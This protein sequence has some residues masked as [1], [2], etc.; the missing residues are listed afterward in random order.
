[1]VK[2]V[3]GWKLSG[4]LTYQ[5]NVHVKNF[6]GGKVRSMTDYVKPGVRDDDPEHIILHVGTNELNLENSSERVAKSTL[7]LANNMVSEKKRVTIS[8]IVPRNG[9]W[10][11]KAEDV[12]GHLTGMCETLNIYFID[13]SSFNPQK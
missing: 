1:M 2:Y 8:G 12:N 7:G 5:K 11:N 4:K 13:N 3:K 9:E 6:P 10:N